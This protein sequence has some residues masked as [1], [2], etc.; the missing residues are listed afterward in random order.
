MVLQSTPHQ[1]TVSGHSRHGAFQPV[2]AGRTPGFE[3][4]SS[5]GTV[6]CCLYRRRRFVRDRRPLR[7]W[8][9]CGH[10]LAA[11]LETTAPG[12]NTLLSSWGWAVVPGIV[13]CR[14]LSPVHSSIAWTTTI[15]PNTP[16]NPADNWVVCRCRADGLGLCLEHAGLN[17]YTGFPNA[18]RAQTRPPSPPTTSRPPRIKQSLK[19]RFRSTDPFQ[20]ES[21]TRDLGRLTIRAHIRFW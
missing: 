5:L 3:A 14:M 4:R 18:E 17:K 16:R 12:D 8:E 10:P 19:S 11:W 21:V 9:A 13:S 7:A 1:A 2:R 20:L 6:R 15:V